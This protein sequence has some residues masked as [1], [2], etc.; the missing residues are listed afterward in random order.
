MR[1]FAACRFVTLQFNYYPF[2]WIFDSMKFSDRINIIHERTLR[3]VYRDK[4]ATFEKLLAKGNSA[5]VHHITLQLLATEIIKERK[6]LTRDIK[7]DVFQSKN[8]KFNLRS[9]ENIFLS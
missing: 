9:Q 8:I 1:V 5:T 3:F 2:V 7:K 6:S 4:K